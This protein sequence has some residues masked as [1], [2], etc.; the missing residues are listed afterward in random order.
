MSETG[1]LF[2]TAIVIADVNDDGCQDLVV[3]APGQN[4]GAGEVIVQ[5]GATLGLLNG[6]RMVLRQGVGGVA[7]VGAAGNAFGAAIGYAPFNQSRQGASLWIGAPYEDVAGE[8]HAGAVTR[9]QLPL[10]TS[11]LTSSDEYTKATPGIPGTAR[12]GDRFGASIR[13][14]DAGIVAVGAPDADVHGAKDA[15]DVTIFTGFAGSPTADVLVLSQA[16]RGMPGKAEAGDHFGAALSFDQACYA[17][18][19]N[20]IGPKEGLVVGVPGEDV[21]SARNAGAIN[22]V[23]DVYWLSVAGIDPSLYLTQNSARIPG[24]AETGDHFGAALDASLS[25]V[26]VGAPGNRVGSV[27]NAG[28]VSWLDIGGARCRPSVVGAATLA[29]GKNGIPGVAARGNEFGAAVAASRGLAIGAPGQ[30]DTGQ[31]AAGTVTSLLPGSCHPCLAACRPWPSART[32]CTFPAT[33]K[34]ETA[35]AASSA[36][37]A[38]TLSSSTEGW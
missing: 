38:P 18:P 19:G 10:S 8:I 37:N 21:G 34:Q 2:G 6:P 7:G 12:A 22:V 26:F 30:I 15:G 28:S 32:P 36:T 23:N 1:D 33:P 11:G 16:S 20:V 25:G 27:R 9:I 13:A 31:A 14:S 24:T 4:S 5:L 17:R 3:G 35:S 29:Q